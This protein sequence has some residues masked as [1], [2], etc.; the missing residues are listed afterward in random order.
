MKTDLRRFP[1]GSNELGGTIMK[2]VDMYKMSVLLVISVLTCA[3]PVFAQ[4]ADPQGYTLLIQQTPAGAGTVTPGD[5]VHKY[6]IGQTVTLS[7]VPQEGF[8]F[9]YWLG[10]VST[11]MEPTTSVSLDSP[12]MVIAVFERA[13]FNEEDEPLPAFGVGRSPA[14]SAGLM[15]SPNP[16]ARPGTVSPASYTGDRTIVYSGPE[17]EWPDTPPSDDDDILVPGDP[18]PEPATLLLLGVGSA[19]LFRRRK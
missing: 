15:A 9:L 12:K 10:D 7:A 16:I 1:Q 18:I 19:A 17:V 14:G 8:R 11:V 5:G 3:I 2:A 13:T 4:Q 6:G